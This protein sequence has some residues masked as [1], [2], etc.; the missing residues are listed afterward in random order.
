MAIIWADNFDN[1]GLDETKLLDGIYAQVAGGTSLETDPD[2]SATG[3][4]MR[5]NQGSDS[6]GFI[7]AGEFRKSYGLSLTT[8]GFSFRMWMP[9]LP[10]SIQE[11]FGWAITDINNEGQVVFRVLSEGSIQ[12]GLGD[13]ST[14]TKPNYPTILGTTSGPVLTAG[15]WNHIEIKAVADEAAGTVEVRVNGVTV[16]SITGADTIADTGSTY[17][18]VSFY[19]VDLNGS[20]SG[21]YYIKDLILWDT[22]GSQNNDFIGTAHIYTLL[23]DADDTLT[24]TPSTGATGWDLVDEQSPVSDAD[25]ISAGDPPPAPNVFTVTNL[26]PDVVSVKALIPVVRARKIDGGDGNVQIGLTGTLTDLGTDHPITTA[27]TYYFDVSE[28]SPD[29]SSPWTPVETDAVKFQID[30]TV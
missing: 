20:V 14:G 13:M 11:L 2:P 12:V 15:A 18:Q 26:P 28:L 10:A 23:P 30:R 1:Y 4:C 19:N 17:N 3:R 8:A 29:T 22:S 21:S 5:I 16:L 24:W 27:F 7:R 6:V 9:N 25:Y